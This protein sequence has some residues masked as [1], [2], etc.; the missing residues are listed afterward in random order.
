MLSRNDWEELGGHILFL[1]GCT[2]FVGSWLLDV[3][4]SANDRYNLGIMVKVLTRDPDGFRARCPHHALNPMIKLLKG[5]VNT[6]DYDCVYADGI[7]HG[8]VEGTGRVLEMARYIPV[9]RFMLISSG[10][11]YSPTLDGE[12]KLEIEREVDRSFQFPV[13]ARLFTFVGPYLPLNGRY[14]VGNF[15]A[16]VL[17]GRP[18]QV[19]NGYSE[20]S[21]LYGADMARWLWK[22]F[23]HGDGIYDVGGITPV[24]I[25]RVGALVRG[26]VNPVNVLSVHYDVADANNYLPDTRRAVNKLGCKQTVSLEEG[27]RRMAEWNKA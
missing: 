10:E 5:D 27:I 13:I 4:S 8:A 18:I 2:R 17:A 9:S 14:A 20:R 15:I 26:I 6:F 7:I 12:R 19:M 16:D 24:N 3:L 22:I 1:T 21:Y 25:G 11:V 23:I